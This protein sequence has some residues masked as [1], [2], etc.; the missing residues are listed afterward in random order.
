MPQFPYAGGAY[1]GP[2]DLDEDGF[3]D[4]CLGGP[5]PVVSLDVETVSIK[6]R[7]LIGI[8]IGLNQ[9][10]S[11]YFTVYPDPSSYL[12]LAWRLLEQA[13][14]VIVHNGIFDL[15]VLMEYINGFFDQIPPK[16][17]E[18]GKPKEYVGRYTVPPLVKHCAEV[19]EDTSLMGQMQGVPSLELSS[20]ARLYLGMNIKTI[21]EVRAEHNLGKGEDMLDLPWGVVAEKCLW[22]CLAT[23]RL[24]WKMQGPYWKDNETFTWYHEDNWSDGFDPSEPNSHWVSEGMIDC[25]QTG[26]ELIPLLLYM[27]ARGFALHYSKIEYWY[28]KLSRQMLTLADTCADH[29]FNPG[30]PQ[31]VGYVLASRGNFLPFTKSRKQ[32]NT[33]EEVLEELDDPLAATVLEYRGV[34]KAKGTYIDP[35]REE[36]RAYSRFRMDLSTSRLAS[37]DRNQMNIPD[38]LREILQADSGEWSWADFSQI[39]MRIAAHVSQD[40]IMLQNY[41]DNED[42]HWTTQQKLWPGTDREDNKYRLPSKTYNFSMLFRAQARTMAQKTKLPLAQATEYRTAW[43]ETYQGINRWQVRTIEDAWNNKYV[44]TIYGRRC[45]LPSLDYTTPGH[46]EKCAC[47]YP[48]QGSG[49]DILARA[50]LIC[51]KLGMD[52][53]LPLHDEILVDGYVDFPEVLHN[54]GK[55]PTPFVAKHGEHWV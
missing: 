28:E 45:R 11:V 49:F 41:A 4:L 40:P 35:Y 39:E 25:Y 42:I 55:L 51:W 48:I 7:T 52:I 8:G 13:E 31:Q 32:L 50:L 54:L 6:D 21:Q 44:E 47:N 20:M 36:L 37:Y 5:Y 19:V 2:K 3:V 46:Y 43:L 24:Y 38:Y 12:N 10:E 34:Q 1:L 27:T 29:G 22:D 16:Q 18:K 53:A 17:L 14:T 26:R 33:S 15:T 30:S 9:Q 23:N